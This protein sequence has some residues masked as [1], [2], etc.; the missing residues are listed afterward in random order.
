MVPTIGML[1]SVDAVALRAVIGNEEV[2]AAQ[3]GMTVGG[4]VEF[5]FV[6]P[7]REDFLSD[8]ERAVDGAGY[9]PVSHFRRDPH[10]I[11]EKEF[12]D[13]ITVHAF[14]ESDVADG[15]VRIPRKAES[16]AHLAVIVNDE[17]VQLEIV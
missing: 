7:N 5:L 15:V 3:T 11:V 2:E 1:L 4:E 16:P 14:I 9:L 10:R 6:T 8:P 12:R 17:F 13:L